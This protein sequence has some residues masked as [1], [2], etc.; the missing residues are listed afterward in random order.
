V[1]VVKPGNV[2]LAGGGEV[3]GSSSGGSGGVVDRSCAVC[4][5]P[6]SQM[7]LNCKVAYY[8]WGGWTS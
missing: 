5:K 6:S 2:N 3:G 1:V 8:W 4:R 7:C